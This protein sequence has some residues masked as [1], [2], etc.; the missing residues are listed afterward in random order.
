MKLLWMSITL[1]MVFIGLLISW[2]TVLD[3][4]L[5]GLQT[6]RRLLWIGVIGLIS[7]YCWWK[8]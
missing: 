1:G 2:L 3:Q 7:A 4:G 6:E 8:S 5:I